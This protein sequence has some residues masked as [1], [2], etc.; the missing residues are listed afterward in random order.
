[1]ALDDWSYKWTDHNPGW[2]TFGGRQTHNAI[3]C[4]RHFLRTRQQTKM[5]KRAAAAII[6]NLQ[7]ES[8]LNPAQW[9]IGYNYDPAHGFGL[10][11]WTPSTKITALADFPDYID[12]D[13]QL[14]HLIED[15]G[16]WSTGLV[17]M[18]TG[19]SSYYDVTVP[20][21]HN[22]EEFFTSS[23]SVDDLTVAWAVYWE[24][25]GAAYLVPETRKVYARHWMQV[26]PWFPYWLI[27][28][29]AQDWRYR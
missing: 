29:K 13:L 7:H 25:P 27:C 19:Y 16:Q 20:I 15:T 4:A 9:E 2:E 1:M 21:L 28:K 14:D 8:F 3:L 24:R 22:M 12:G 18:D 5:S 23:A 26:I 17:N 6:G 10:G 11:Q